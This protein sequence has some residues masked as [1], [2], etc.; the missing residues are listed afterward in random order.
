MEIQVKNMTPPAE[1]L[2]VSPYVVALLLRRASLRH[3]MPEITL[4]LR[5][6]VVK[7]TKLTLVLS[8]EPFKWVQYTY[9]CTVI[10][11]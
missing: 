5:M 4:N 9:K 2:P 10:R 6:W 3:L 11:T 7:C 1:L 8:T